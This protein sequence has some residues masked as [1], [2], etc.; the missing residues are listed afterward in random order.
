MGPVIRP[1]ASK[2]KSAVM[3]MLRKLPQF[4]P[5]ELVVAEEVIDTYLK[6]PVHSGYHALVA[7]VSSSIA[8]Y[9]CYGPTPMTEGTWDIYWLAVASE[10]Q[11]QGIGKALV[12]SSEAEIKKARGRLAFVETSSRPEY[13]R[14]RHFYR[15]QGYK[16]ACRIADFYAPGDDKLIFQKRLI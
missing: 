11:R 12:T 6:D 14:A 8:G 1:M 3:Q 16:L 10:E 5:A 4:K 7:E 9:I 13:D 2:D 15:S